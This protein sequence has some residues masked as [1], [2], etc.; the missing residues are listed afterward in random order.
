[1]NNEYTIL[2]SHMMR[3]MCIDIYY[4]LNLYDLAVK[5]DPADISRNISGSHLGIYNDLC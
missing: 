4:R 2:H 5:K 1:M 3:Y